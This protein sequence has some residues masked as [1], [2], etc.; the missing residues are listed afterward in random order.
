M[1][2]TDSRVLFQSADGKIN[3]GVWFNDPDIELDDIFWYNILAGQIEISLEDGNGLISI[4]EELNT[5]S[6]YVELL[7]NGDLESTRF[8]FT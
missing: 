7:R 3:M 8:I 4:D 5:R 1:K 6:C 2:G